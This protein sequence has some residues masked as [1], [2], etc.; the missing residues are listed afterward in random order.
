M[1]K[2][3]C[4]HCG[5][6]LIH[7]CGCAELA[8]TLRGRLRLFREYHPLGMKFSNF[9]SKTQSRYWRWKNHKYF[10]SRNK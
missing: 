10:T 6:E 9:M 5:W 1:S 4:P 7:Q 8:K 3:R 2:A